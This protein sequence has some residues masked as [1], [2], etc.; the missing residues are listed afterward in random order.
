MRIHQQGPQR[1]LARHHAH[2][3]ELRRQAHAA[4]RVAVQRH[5]RRTEAKHPRKRDTTSRGVGGGETLGRLS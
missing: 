1:A 2:V 3:A 5:V 4:S